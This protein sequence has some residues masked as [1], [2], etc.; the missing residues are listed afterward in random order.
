MIQGR[1][2]ATGANRFD[3]LL[4]IS[5]APMILALSKTGTA[6]RKPRFGRLYFLVVVKQAS[7]VTTDIPADSWGFGDRISVRE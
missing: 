5:A 2:S 1:M 7:V 6:W 4:R 3:D